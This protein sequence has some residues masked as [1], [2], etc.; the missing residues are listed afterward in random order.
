[1]SIAIPVLCCASVLAAS[2]KAAIESM[3]AEIFAPYSA[4]ETTPA[5]PWQR[6]IYS[7]ETGALIAHWEKVQPS[8]EPD[9]LNDGDWLCQCQDFDHKAFQAKTLVVWRPSRDVVKV[10]MELNLGH[11]VPRSARL[12]MARQGGEWRLDDIHGPDFPKGLKQK[13][14]ET[15][16]ED[17]KLL[18]E[19][20]GA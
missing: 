8:G 10:S 16:A 6:R 9:A 4:E 15:I 3:V 17:E 7:T 11:G 18:A 1:M 5:A 19:G 2:D 14:R 20:N 13:L 12:T